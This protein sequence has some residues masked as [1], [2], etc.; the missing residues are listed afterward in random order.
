MMYVMLAQYDKW[1]AQHLRVFKSR[2]VRLKT[3]FS[4]F[5]YLYVVEIWSVVCGGDLVSCPNEYL[6]P[7]LLN[8]R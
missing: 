7:Y 2:K 8:L 6:I 5:R 4:D 1:R 3:L